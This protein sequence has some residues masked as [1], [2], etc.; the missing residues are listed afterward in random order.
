MG[1]EISD[2]KMNWQTTQQKKDKVVNSL[3]SG[4]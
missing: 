3:T 1:I 4:I 2:L